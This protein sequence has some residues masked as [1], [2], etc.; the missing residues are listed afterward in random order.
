M[1]T[2]SSNSR[3]AFLD[4]RVAATIGLLILGAAPNA[5]RA[6]LNVWR[7]GGDGESWQRSAFNSAAIDFGNSDSIEILGFASDENIIQSLS[8]GEGSPRDYV[9]ERA[10]A[11]IWDSLT[12]K[13]SNAPLVDGDV[14]SS[15]DDR[16]KRFGVSQEGHRFFLDLGAPFPV[17]RFLFFP[18]QSGADSDGRPFSSDFIRSYQV[19]VSDGNSYNEETPPRPIYNLISRVEFTREDSADTIFPLQF[20]RFLQMQVLST[21]PFEIAEFQ[22]FGSGFAP[23]ASYLSNVVSLDEPG[24][25]SQIKWELEKLRREEDVVTVDSLANAELSIRMRTGADDTPLVYF[26]IV[27]RFTNEQVEVAESAYNSLPS[28]VRG[29]VEEDLENWSSWSPPFTVSPARINLPSPRQYFQLEISMKSLSILDAMRLNNIDIEYHTPP[30]AAGVLGEVSLLEEPAPPGDV[31]I[32][33]AGVFATFAYDLL[34]DVD[35]NSTG[36]NALRIFTSE[37]QPRLVDFLVGDPPESVVPDSTAEEAGSLTLFFPSRRVESRAGGTL[38]VIFDAQVFVQGTFFNAEVFDTE[39]ED[40]PQ[41]VLPG[42]ANPEVLTNRLIVLTSDESAQDLL[43]F[44]EVT[45]QA[46][47]PN[48]DGVN[49]ESDINVTLVQLVLPVD[50]DVEIFDLG[51][52]RVRS[53]FSGE[54]IIGAHTWSWDGR[55]D[56]EAVVPPGIYVVAVRVGAGREELV[57]TGTVALAY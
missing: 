39:S 52:R 6:E 31:T 45:P 53:L 56:S 7:L 13:R 30:L 8:W 11:R 25:F 55:D 4:L 23:R 50:V 2:G 21:N 41:V 38:R 35:G 27:N 20:V 47:S 37:S 44:F 48:G 14:N 5:S 17:R 19:R 29:V 18:R 12:L 24:N 34:A 22:I 36:F 26:E 9:G 40:S 51:G 42:D 54:E 43:P 32:A 33:P 28:D 49:D 46:F 16:F 10:S 57:R 15:S 3:L 1:R